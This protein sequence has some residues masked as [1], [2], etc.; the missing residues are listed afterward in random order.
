MRLSY[1]LPSST[2]NQT[3]KEKI[4]T[5]GFHCDIGVKNCPDERVWS[6]PENAKSGTIDL[7]ILYL[8]DDRLKKQDDSEM[9]TAELGLEPSKSGSESIL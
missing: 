1:P 2:R 4:Q 7:I 8:K 3:D 9:T 5:T 6:Q